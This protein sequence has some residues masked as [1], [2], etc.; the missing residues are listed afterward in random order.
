MKMH[1]FRELRQQNPW[2]LRI[3]GFEHLLIENEFEDETRAQAESRLREFVRHKLKYIAF[4]PFSTLDLNA[5]RNDGRDT[6]AETMICDPYYGGS[7]DAW[8]EE[9][10]KITFGIG[11][12]NDRH[13]EEPLDGMSVENQ[14]EK[15]RIWYRDCIIKHTKQPLCFHRVVK[16][17]RTG[18]SR[19]V[20][21]EVTVDIYPMSYGV[22]PCDVLPPKPLTPQ[23]QYYRQAVLDGIEA[24]PVFPGTVFNPVISEG[25][26]EAV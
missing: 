16:V 15:T 13:Y 6:F 25:V 20:L 9:D 4:R 19:D 11:P 7:W 14:I 18:P 21:S 5:V 12:E 17:T 1:K 3:L 22:R 26:I 23:E 10:W 2:I 24:P 8:Y